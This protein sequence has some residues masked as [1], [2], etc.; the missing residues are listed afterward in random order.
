MN[1]FPSRTP[2]L[3]ALGGLLAFAGHAIAATANIDAGALQRQTEQGLRARPDAPLRNRPEP[4][5]PSPPA[6]DA[7]TVTVTAFEFQGNTLLSQEA[8]NQVVA[9]FL[10]RPLSFDG[11]QEAA[12][13]VSA[14]YREAGWVVRAFFPKQAIDSGRVTLQIVEAQFGEISLTG[15]PSQRIAA[16]RIFSTVERAQPRGALLNAKQLDRALLLLDDLPGIDATGNLVEGKKPGQTD[17]A[18]NVTDADL[19]VTHFYADNFGARAT[20]AQR[21]SLNFMLNS[22]LGWGDQ[23]LVNGLH[24]QGSQYGRMAW[25]VPL[26]YDGLRVGW[27]RSYLNYQLVGDFEKLA[28]K[29]AASATGLDLS[30]P[31]VRSQLQNLSIHFVHDQKSFLNLANGA[32]ASNYTLQVSNVSL[33]FN[34]YDPWGGGGFNNLTLAASGG[35]VN[36]DQSP[37]QAQ[38]AAGPQT[39]GKFRKTNL[40]LS[41]QQAITPKLS[42]Y[43]SASTQWA[44]KNLD[45][46]EKIYLGGAN[47]VRAYPSSEGGGSRGDIATLELRQRLGQSW[48]VTAFYDQGRLSTAKP[49]E[50]PAGLTST[51][52]KGRGVAVAWQALTGVELKLTVAR[53]MGLNPLRNT[54]TGMDGDGTLERDRGWFNATV[55]Y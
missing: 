44:N 9:P 20:G 52:L 38:D 11:L 54:N 45:S 33:N 43:V 17:L 19:L 10:N 24:T 21:Q 7:V 51:T 26:G 13:A 8:L 14:A 40:S 34:A 28:A 37:H 53:R 29:G 15:K 32:T 18:L 39:A 3:F 50:L 22:L 55:T 27:H 25:S 42:F 6:R 49:N 48:T 12:Q 36:L 46:S 16:S 2:S 23:L 35:R 47:G 5:P 4:Q 30:Y 31:L 1:S 41:R